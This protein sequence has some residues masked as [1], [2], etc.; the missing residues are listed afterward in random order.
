M[1]RALPLLQQP[2]PAIAAAPSPVTAPTPPPAQSRWEIEGPFTSQDTEQRVLKSSSPD[3]LPR[4]HF[5]GLSSPQQTP[6]PLSTVLLRKSI[7]AFYKVRYLF[8][9]SFFSTCL[10][11]PY[12]SAELRL[13]EGK[14]PG[15]QAAKPGSSQEGGEGGGAVRLCEGQVQLLQLSPG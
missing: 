12:S 1:L 8:H 7:P 5:P 13:S 10:S 14:R 15:S 2:P 9:L 11:T 3:S 4:S 6:S